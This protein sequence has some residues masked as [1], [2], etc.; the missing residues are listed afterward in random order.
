LALPS[1]SRAKRAIGSRLN[2]LCVAVNAGGFLRM[3][4]FAGWAAL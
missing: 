4:R 1:D 2:R 3:A